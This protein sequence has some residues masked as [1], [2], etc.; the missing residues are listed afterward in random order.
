MSHNQAYFG[1]S[2]SA[3]SATTATKVKRYKTLI[4]KTLVNFTVSRQ[5]EKFATKTI[6]FSTNP[7]LQKNLVIT[8]DEFAIDKNYFIRVNII[9]APALA[10]KKSKQ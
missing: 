8:M 10:P 9:S 4:E 6:W 7:K 3:D 2:A 1:Q 5:A